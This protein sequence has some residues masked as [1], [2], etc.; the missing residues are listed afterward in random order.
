MVV[1]GGVYVKESSI[2]AESVAMKESII[3]ACIS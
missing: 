2:G 1:F 3:D